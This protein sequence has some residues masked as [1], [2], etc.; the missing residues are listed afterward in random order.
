[1]KPL[2]VISFLLLNAC[3][4]FFNM[5]A[6]QEL[7]VFSDPASNAPARSLS[8]KYAGKW[9]GKSQVG[10][11]HNAN[12][13]ML[14][15]QFG[16]NKKLM[17]RTGLSLGNMYNL[18][19]NRLTFESVNVYA[20][21]RFL[22]YDGVH[23][24]FRAAAFLKGVFSNN[25]LKYDELTSEGDQTAVQA[26]LIFTQ[27]VHK[28]AVSS[29]FA[30]TEVMDGERFLKYGGPRNFGYRSLNYSLSAGYLLLPRTYSNY[31]QT[32]LNLYIEL[33]GSSGQG[34]E[35]YNGWTGGVFRTNFSYLDLAPALQLIIKSNAKLNLGYRFQLSG[36]AFRM[37]N[38]AFLVSY[39]RTFLNTFKR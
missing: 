4:L 38:S 9:V 12:R 6:A 30:L 36:N 39:E 13:Q 33:L 34:P 28:L 2:Y 3:I 17:L 22:S 10:H 5:A 21:Y 24:H 31:N 19:D 7:Y 16:I 8:I 35:M 15:S 20:K 1:M 11:Q 29:T 14:E 27:L 18:D 26:G 32:N 37:S 23:K 25:D